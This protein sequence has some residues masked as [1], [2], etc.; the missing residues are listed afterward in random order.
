MGYKK[1]IEKSSGI[2]IFN[3]NSTHTVLHL[4]YPSSSI[5]SRRLVVDCISFWRDKRSRTEVEK[6]RPL[7]R[8]AEGGEGNGT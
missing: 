8:V 5:G 4:L 6:I 3:K 7:G 1:T 2:D